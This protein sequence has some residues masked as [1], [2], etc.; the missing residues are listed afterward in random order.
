MNQEIQEAITG[1][2][3][4]MSQGFQRLHERL[5]QVMPRTEHGVI[6][7]SIKR[8]VGVLERVAFG[9]IAFIL[10]C[11]AGALLSLIIK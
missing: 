2:R 9:G 11:V 5:D 7:D 8:R 1:L 4:D 6:C 3:S 10:I